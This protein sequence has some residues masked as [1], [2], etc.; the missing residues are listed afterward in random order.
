M[1]TPEEKGRDN[2]YHVAIVF[3]D[4]LYN[5]LVYKL[6]NSI[7]FWDKKRV[8]PVQINYPSW[9]FAVEIDDLMSFTLNTS[10]L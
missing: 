10:R 8:P 6:F 1:A 5:W 4:I 3:I 9:V 2:T 7:P